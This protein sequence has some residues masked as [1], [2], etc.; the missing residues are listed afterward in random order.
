R[1]EAGEL[2][3]LRHAGHPW[4]RRF[5]AP[6]PL[7]PAIRSWG[8]ITPLVAVGP[9]SWSVDGGV[10]PEC[11]QPA[12][13]PS[14]RSDGDLHR[15]RWI[16]PNRSE[17]VEAIDAEVEVV[18][19]DTVRLVVSA[20]PGPAAPAWWSVGLGIV[21]EPPGPGTVAVE[22]PLGPVEVPTTSSSG[23]LR[24]AGRHRAAVHTDFGSLTAITDPEAA[25]AAWPL[26]G[27]GGRVSCPIMVT[28]RVPTASTQP[29]VVTL[30]WASA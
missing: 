7:G 11:W 16:D 5:A 9:W 2:V 27:A 23:R 4:V 25:M 1:V 21:V 12:P 22:T 30:R 3:E 19:D 6:E 29:V 28:R 17:L 26:E 14:M 15:L 20:I 13:V 10:D 8:G 18:D 24:L